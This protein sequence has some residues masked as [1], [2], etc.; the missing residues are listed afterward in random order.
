MVGMALRAG[1]MHTIKQRTA[2]M[3]PHNATDYYMFNCY[4]YNQDVRLGEWL[5]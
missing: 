2:V 5:A 3:L 4:S 1:A